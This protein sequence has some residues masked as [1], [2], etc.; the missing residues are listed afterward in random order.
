MNGAEVRNLRLELTMAC[1]RQT[2]SARRGSYRPARTFIFTRRNTMADRKTAENRP[3]NREV[4]N[5]MIRRPA[6]AG[7]PPR[8]ATEPPAGGTKSSQRR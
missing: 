2:A 3:K 7:K 8:P 5:E 4:E 6:D 1:A